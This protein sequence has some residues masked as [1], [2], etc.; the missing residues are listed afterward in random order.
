MK[1][2]I[3]PITVFLISVAFFVIFRESLSDLIE[4]IKGIGREG[5]HTG[6]D[7]SDRTRLDSN[8]PDTV[9]TLREAHLAEIERIAQRHEDRETKIIKNLENSV[10]EFSNRVGDID[11]RVAF[12][13]N[14]R[15]IKPMLA[16]PPLKTAPK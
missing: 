2:L 14:N 15:V 12:I 7:A 16:A 13:E 6:E 8:P 1:E 4:R 3:W 9:A 11:R 5:I 10:A